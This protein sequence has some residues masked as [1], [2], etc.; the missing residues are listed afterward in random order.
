MTGAR[1]DATRGATAAGSIGSKTGG[2]DV[3]IA[4]IV[5]KIAATGGKIA[6]IGA[7]EPA[8]A[9]QRVLRAFVFPGFLTG[10]SC[11]RKLFVRFATVSSHSIDSAPPV[12]M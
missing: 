12:R 7:A 9:R 8:K 2:T 1:I 3:R 10:E 6:A 5:A 4:G 11:F